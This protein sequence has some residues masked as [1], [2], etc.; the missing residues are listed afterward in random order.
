MAGP[1]TIDNSDN[2]DHEARSSL[3]RI[4][5]IGAAKQKW[6]NGVGIHT[7]QELAEVSVNDLE[8]RLDDKGYTTACSE[9]E[10]WLSQAQDLK[11][12]PSDSLI[13]GMPGADSG[14]I[15]NF[16]DEGIP[17]GG[18]ISSVEISE[19]EEIS[20]E[21]KLPVSAVE[22]LETHTVEEVETEEEESS[23][24]A[25][26]ISGAET[27]EPPH[28]SVGEAE[29]ETFASFTV[30]FQQ[31]QA[32]DRNQQ[33]IM[34]RHRETDTVKSWLGVEPEHLQGWMLAQVASALP[35][36]SV[37]RRPTT[38]TPIIIQIKQLHLVQPPDQGMPILIQHAGHTVPNSIR[39]DDAFALK[40]SFQLTGLSAADIAKQHVTYSIQWHAKNLAAPHSIISL[41]DL[42]PQLL[43]QGQT[44]YQVMLP[45]A[46]LTSGIY[47][48]QIL[49][50][51]QGVVALSA[52]CEIPE[53][54]V[55]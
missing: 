36:E 49:L 30:E 13:E 53:L 10:E 39:A 42:P 11:T 4:R 9:L 48:L 29:W 22:I 18:E 40:V 34:V 46:I 25:R 31:R 27:E 3:T 7:V 20:E 35:P 2:G 32:G 37:V 52:F 16:S 15:T 54:Q 43:I 41:D 26:G 12:E 6:L 21:D 38:E 33:Q 19:E 44:V 50:T 5:G 23:T 55:I 24:S 8:A 45:T 14:D 51:L 47:R 1:P 28:L 17:G